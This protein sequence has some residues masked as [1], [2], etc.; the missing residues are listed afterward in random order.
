M[1]QLPSTIDEVISRMEEIVHQCEQNASRLGYFAALY[2]QVTIEIR[3]NIIERTFDNPELLERLAVTFAGR[4]FTALEEFESSARPTAPWVVAFEASNRRRPIILQHLLLGMNAHINFDLAIASAATSPSVD[5]LT[6]KADFM[7]VNDILATQV[8]QVLKS[9]SKCSPLIGLVT[10]FYKHT[11]EKVAHFSMDI[12]RA[13]SWLTAEDLAVADQARYATL[14][15]T[16]TTNSTQLGRKLR[17]PKF[18]VRTLFAIIALLESNNVRRNIGYL[19]GS[20]AK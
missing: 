9:M 7:K 5:I 2:R 17:S 6:L 15:Q 3:R 8:P 16:S 14:L 13:F 19:A 4:Y 18:L 20:S 12:A 10:V 1:Q 11:E